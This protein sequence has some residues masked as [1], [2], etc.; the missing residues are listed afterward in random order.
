MNKGTRVTSISSLTLATALC[1][2]LVACSAGS[3]PGEA[4]TAAPAAA[5]ATGQTAQ[6]YDLKGKVMALDKAG[7][8]LTVDAGDIP[9]FMSAMTMPYPVKDEH[10]LDNLSVGDQI[11]AKVVSSGG[12]FWLEN[13]AAVKA[14]TPAK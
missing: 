12:D 4:Q 10:M 13:I 5:P 3:K 1:L 8:N 14:D 6:R 7:K 11:T 2:G 9:G